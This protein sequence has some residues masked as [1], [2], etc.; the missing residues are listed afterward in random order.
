MGCFVVLAL[1][2]SD[3][4]LEDVRVLNGASLRLEKGLAFVLRGRKNGYKSG[5]RKDWQ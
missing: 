5:D 4:F 3:R 2:N 1:G